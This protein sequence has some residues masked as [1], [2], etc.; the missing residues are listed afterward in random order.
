M[1]KP[2]ERLRKLALENSSVVVSWAVTI[3]ST[4][5]DRYRPRIPAASRFTRWRQVK[6]FRPVPSVR[7]LKE[8]FTKSHETTRK[9][10]SLRNPYGVVSCDLVDRS[11]LFSS[12]NKP[13]WEKIWNAKASAILSCNAF[14]RRSFISVDVRQTSACHSFQPAE[15][16]DRDE[17]M[18]VNLHHL[19][20]RARRCERHSRFFKAAIC[21]CCSSSCSCCF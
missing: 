19:H 14:R 21:F 8:R 6:G 16:L 9:P 2:F 5:T 18:E 17:R 4:R 13:D 3:R 20:G 1:I 11:L 7:W 15:F 12:A 10:T